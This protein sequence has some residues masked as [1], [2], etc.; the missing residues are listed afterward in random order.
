METKTVNVAEL[1]IENPE[2]VKSV[3]VNNAGLMYTPWDIRLMFSEVVP[4]LAGADP[5]IFL[6]AQLVMHPGHAKALIGSLNQVVKLFEE[7]YGE[8]KLGEAEKP[9]ALNSGG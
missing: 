5:S 2:G 1:K 7:Q 4:N 9:S 3:Y 8:L 6:R